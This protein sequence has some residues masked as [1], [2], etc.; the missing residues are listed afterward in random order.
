MWRFEFTVVADLTANVFSA[1]FVIFLVLSA[2]PFA[3]A[4]APEGRDLERQLVLVEGRPLSGAERVDLL[5]ART[6][7]ARPSVDLF[8]DRAALPDGTT[9]DAQRDGLS[10]LSANVGLF[11]FANDR[12]AAVAEGLRARGLPFREIDVPA[13]L[14]DPAAPDRGWSPAFLQ[15]AA[16]R[17]DRPAFVAALARLLDAGPGGPSAR[18]AATT[19]A[20]PAGEAAT[21]AD[22]IRGVARTASDIAMPLAGLLVLALIERRF[23]RRRCRSARGG[24]NIGTLPLASPDRR[25]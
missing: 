18:P 5:Y 20:A 23:P 17:L 15:L 4:A 3:P 21:L 6:D 11:V 19:Q 12:Y 24:P 13:A 25:I 8:A 2:A 9:L 7:P 1:C 14:R 16:Q 10:Q 22:R